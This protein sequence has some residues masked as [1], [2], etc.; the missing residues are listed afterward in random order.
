MNE[1]D[2][3]IKLAQTQFNLEKDPLKRVV[4]SKRLNVLNLR[5][6]IENIQMKIKQLS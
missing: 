1:L 3:K 6:E 5:K 4:I 2:D